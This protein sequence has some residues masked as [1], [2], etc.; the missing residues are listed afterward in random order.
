MGA[1]LLSQGA[2][3]WQR[4]GRA[5]HKSATAEEIRDPE[6][7]NLN[8]EIAVEPVRLHV[9]QAVAGQAARPPQ[10]ANTKQT[11]D[12][13]ASRQLSHQ[14]VS[15]Q[16]N[17]LLLHMIHMHITAP[18]LLWLC[19]S[20]IQRDLTAWLQLSEQQ[21]VQRQRPGARHHH[22]FA[23][24]RLILSTFK[25]TFAFFTLD[26]CRPRQQLAFQFVFFQ[27]GAWLFAAR[28]CHPQQQSPALFHSD[29]PRI[30][31]FLH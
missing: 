31:C 5:K 14:S 24:G 27:S 17:H 3:G 4:V 10:Q 11:P 30:C 16:A 6:P 26:D 23:W 20:S 12:L 2:E 7:R 21:H 28:P 9:V 25:V 22:A 15:Q 13:R 8:N 29:T 1:K 18:G 19:S